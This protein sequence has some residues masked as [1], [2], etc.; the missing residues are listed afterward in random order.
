MEL[1]PF[2]ILP[3][4]AKPANSVFL[5]NLWAGSKM[6][7]YGRGSLPRRWVGHMPYT[8]H[9]F[10][11]AEFSPELCQSSMSRALSQTTER[12]LPSVKASPDC[13]WTL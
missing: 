6:V 2:F 9:S 7:G 11:V 13:T 4:V 8:W 1:R 5:S 12:S 10:R 3:R